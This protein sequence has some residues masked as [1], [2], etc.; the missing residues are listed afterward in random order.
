MEPNF[1]INELS[2]RHRLSK[3]DRVRLRAIAGIDRE[4]VGL[5]N[6]LRSSLAMIAAGLGALGMIFWIAANWN[7]L[8]RAAQ[9]T[10]IE[11]AL[12]AAYVGAYKLPRSRVAFGLLAM[13]AAG[14]LLAYFGQTYQ[15]GAD[16]W[17]L[18]A[19]WAGL[20]LPLCIGVRHDALWVG[21]ALIFMTAVSLWVTSHSEPINSWDR[22]DLS[23][24]FAG[25][26]MAFGLAF[27][28]SPLCRRYTGA[29]PWTF[30]LTMCLAVVPATATLAQTMY[31]N[32]LTIYHGLGIAFLFAT[33]AIFSTR[34]LFDLFAVC[35][36]VVSL[37]ALCMGLVMHLVTK[38]N[39]SWL[40]GLFSIGIL[41]VLAIAISGLVLLAGAG[42]L[43][44]IIARRNG[45][46]GDLQ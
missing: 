16:P 9:F 3:D 40:G 6:A 18:F 37:N 22:P 29:G 8:G 4:P 34:R 12:L 21:W 41:G 19:L 11:A 15:S 31:H 2:S 42:Q 32:H 1:A 46:S 35:L 44:A 25:W 10:L 26:C 14:G 33:I 45:V 36:T 20:T 13:L 28:V 39:D 30:R 24:R 38:Q 17:Q 5:T 23:Y 7:L 43:I 27:F